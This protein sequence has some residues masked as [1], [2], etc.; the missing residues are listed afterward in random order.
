MSKNKTLKEEVL[1]SENE[2]VSE[3]EQVK[4]A[5]VVTD[6][7]LSKPAKEDK[8]KTKDKKEKPKKKDK[9]PKE[10]KMRRRVKETVSELKKVTWP[11]FGE[12]CKKTGIVLSVVVLF[13]LIVFGLDVGL[14]A[15]FGLLTGRGA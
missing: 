3:S 1:I 8:K 12:V 7:S 14:G 13:G 10:K 2:Q 5:V 6:E 15:L 11:S 4:D 9:K